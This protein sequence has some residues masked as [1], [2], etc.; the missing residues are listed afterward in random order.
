MTMESEELSIRGSLSESS[1]PEL[2]ASISRSK[3]TGILN[4][5]DAGRW[6]AIYFKEGRIIY[7][8][9]NAQDDRLGEFLLKTGKVTVRQFL[10]ASKLIK[11]DKKLGAVLVDQGIISPDDLFVAIHRHAEAV[12]YSLFEWMRGEYEFVIKDLSAEGPMVLDFDSSNVILEGIRRLKS[13][14]G[15]MPASVRSKRCCGPRKGLT[16]SPTS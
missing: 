16:V 3:E 4:F 8:M 14:R 7:A 6:K 11:P 15:S 5:H 10:E 12:V 13:T 1:L 2:L 9:S